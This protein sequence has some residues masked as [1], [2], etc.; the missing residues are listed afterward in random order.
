MESS[1]KVPIPARLYHYERNRVIGRMNKVRNFQ[2][3]TL[4]KE[5]IRKLSQQTSSHS[6]AAATCVASEGQRNDRQDLQVR[7]HGTYTPY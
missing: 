5:H 1:Q 3:L 6:I 4:C 7:M 2:T